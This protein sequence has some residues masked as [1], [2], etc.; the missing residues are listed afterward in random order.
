MQSI[1]F[2]ETYNSF[3]NENELIDIM[4]QLVSKNSEID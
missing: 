1:T 4:K 2:P 3:D